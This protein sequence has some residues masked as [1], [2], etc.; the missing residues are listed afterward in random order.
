MLLALPVFLACLAF[1]A[2]LSF[3]A[4]L[5]Y[6]RSPSRIECACLLPH[7]SCRQASG[8]RFNHRAAARGNGASAVLHSPSR[9]IQPVPSP[10]HAGRHNGA[11]WALRASF[12]HA[13]HASA[14]RLG[15]GWN[16]ELACLGY[17]PTGPLSYCVP[18]VTYACGLPLPAMRVI[19]VMPAIGAIAAITAARW[20]TATT[21]ASSGAPGRLPRAT[22][23]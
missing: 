1:C 11:S 16:R 6:V 15:G 3:F 10:K 19:T 14:S 21:V 22:S 13:R 12:S 2:L 18:L 20:P 4:F 7:R 5:F 8:F 9:A 23:R 17:A